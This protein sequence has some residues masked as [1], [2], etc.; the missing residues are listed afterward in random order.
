[1]TYA[2]IYDEIVSLC[3]PGVPVPENMPVYIRNKIRTAQRNINRDYNFWFTIAIA[4]I[5]TV[6]GTQQYALP[7]NFKDIEE[8]WFTVQGQAY[9]TPP[10]NRKDITQHIQ[11]G[12]H[13]S[14]YTTEY[15]TD[16]RIDGA[17]IYLYPVPK[18]IRTLNIMYWSFLPAVP[19]DTDANFRAYAEDAIGL[20]CGEAIVFNVISQ[21]KLAQDEWQSSTIYK[22]LYLEALEGAMS[23]DKIRRQIPE[24][25]YPKRG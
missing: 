12:L 14:N 5:T 24:N 8:V 3:F 9:G 17:N 6:A 11:E 21:I 7:T 4:T 20:Y 15:P 1:M 25:I 22:Q 13:E 18:E 19:V 16:Y 2:E 10:L 23:E